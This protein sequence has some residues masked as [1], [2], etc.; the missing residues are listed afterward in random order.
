MSK[1]HF[2]LF[3]VH[4]QCSML[5]E[6]LNGHMGVGF[7]GI[8]SNKGVID[9]TIGIGIHCYLSYTLSNQTT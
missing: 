3:I 9:H 7:S 5:L 4:V 2:R 1:K 6:A 8:V